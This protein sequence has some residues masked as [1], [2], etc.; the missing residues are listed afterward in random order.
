M[1]M[2]KPKAPLLSL[3]ASG[4]LGGA[5]VFGR[6]K[7]IDVAR[8]YV[9][10]A[11]PQTAAQQTQRGYMTAATATWHTI[12]SDALEGNDKEAWNRYAGTLG[13]MSGYNAFTKAWMDESVAGGT[14]AGHFFDQNVTVSTANAVELDIDSDGV[15]ASPVTMHLG[16]SLTFFAV[17]DTQNAVAGVASF[18]PINTG[19][20]AGE[21][22]YVWFE[23]GTPG[24]DYIRSGI[25]TFVLT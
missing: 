11:N 16:N 19:F 17:E 10:P 9:V 18:G 4:K 24:V 3:G 23:S 5:L 20:S 2:A 22:V 25:Y 7:G 12:G 21:R 6:W 15:G 14:P 13:P 8:E 1:S